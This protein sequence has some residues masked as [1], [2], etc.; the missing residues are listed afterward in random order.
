MDDVWWF[1]E[2]YHYSHSINGVMSSHCFKLV[3]DK[4]MIGGMLFG[5]LAMVGQWK[6]YANSE[7]EILE[8]RRLVCI[9]DTPKN[10]ESYFIGKALKWLKRYTDIKKI[11]SY[12][13]PSHGHTGIIYRASNFKYMG[14]LPNQKVIKYQ[15]K[16][17]HDKAIRTKYNGVLKPFAVKIKNALKNGEASMVPVEGKHVYVYE[18]NGKNTMQGKLC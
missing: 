4:K 7:N 10:T 18:L 13:D 5:R 11:V 15:G 6:K 12:A 8:L 1:I 16:T 17:Y 2:K 14:Q 3:D 9:D